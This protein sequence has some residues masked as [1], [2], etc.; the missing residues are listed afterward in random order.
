[1]KPFLRRRRVVLGL[2][3]LMVV[4]L[5]LWAGWRATQVYSDLKAAESAGRA[6]MSAAS[7]GDGADLDQA[8]ADL[9]THA[10]AA[11]SRT[12]GPTWSALGHLPVLGDDARGVRAMADSL[13]EIARRGADPLLETY[14]GVQ[15]VNRDG[16]FDL[17]TV[18]GLRGPVATARSAFSTAAE[19]MDREDPSGFIGKVQG[20]YE[21]FRSLVHGL[22]S[23][24]TS[25]ES[26]TEILPS[27]LG[28]EGERT[29]L[30]VFLNNAEIRS[31]GGLPGAYAEV[32]AENGKL[33]L[34]S[35]GTE[36]TLGSE[37][38][39]VLPLSKAERELFGDQL[40]IYFRDANFLQDMPRTSE[41]LAAHWKR[42]T[43]KDLDGVLTLDTVGMSY[44]LDGAG[45]VRTPDGVTLTSANAVPELL[46]RTYVV[47]AEPKVQDAR[48]ASVASSTFSALTH[49][50]RDQFALVKG[51]GRAADEGR[52]LFHSFDPAEQDV[53]AG[54]R[55]AG[56][57][58]AAPRTSPEIDLG[59]DDATG[60]KMSYYLRYA[61]KVS[62]GACRDGRQHVQG[63]MRVSSTV[64]LRQVADLP[65]YV[66]GGGQFGT[67]PGDQTVITRLYGPAGGTIDAVTIDGET[68]DIDVVDLKG[69]PATVLALS[70][71]PEQISTVEWTM[72]S[73]KGQTGPIHLGVTPGIEPGDLSRAVATGCA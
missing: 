72:I 57:L 54:K 13:D 73:G 59:F 66:T 29:Y 47:L 63:S 43:G 53:L 55:I 6:A 40:G 60:S 11:A 58:S 2:P 5:G 49:D 48:F 25:G 71:S 12:G 30:M 19:T 9:R 18:E 70:L 20:R 3:L 67:T 69:R 56:E 64:S 26:A 50:V 42:A 31:S 35:Q 1:M 61:P 36:S 38:T 62:A 51:L 10:A 52:L 44:L 39:P 45:A 22:E 14:R 7:A 15:E 8:V 32:R 41:L 27:V 17:A 23:S 4:L 65:S 37:E 46:H 33:S 28:G 16:R 21:D 24:L 34:V 68:I